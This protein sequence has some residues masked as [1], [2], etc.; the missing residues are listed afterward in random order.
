[1]NDSGDKHIGADYAAEQK[2]PK[3]F[4]VWIA[5]IFGLVCMVVA[6]GFFDRFSNQVRAGDAL[7]SVNALGQSVAGKPVSM[8]WIGIDA[9]DV[10]AAIASQ[11]GLEEAKG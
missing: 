11:L 10:D 2:C 5:F 6:V 8:A 4:Q 9:E 1:M 7:G 3:N